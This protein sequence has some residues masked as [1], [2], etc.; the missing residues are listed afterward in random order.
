MRLAFIVNLY[1]PYIVGGNEMLCDD[2]VKALRARGHTVCVLCGRGRELPGPP[3]VTG[4]LEIDLDRRQDTFLGGRLP[5]PWEAFKLHVFSPA[6]YRSTRRW[7]VE[8]QPEL[9]VV[10]NLHM[11]SLAPLLAVKHHGRPF[12]VHLFDKWLYYSLVDL[13]T[14]LR[15]Q[16]PWKRWLIRLSRATLQPLLRRLVGRLDLVS[17]SRFLKDFYLRA[18]FAEGTIEVEHLGVPTSDFARAS[19]PVAPGGRP[20][21]LLFVG[22]LWEGKGPQTAVRALGLLLR[23]GV[24][25]SLDIYGEGVP[26]FVAALEALIEQEGVG[27]QV[28]LHGRVPKSAVPAL[29]RSHDVLVFPSEWDEPFAAVPLEAMSCGMVVVATT[30]GGTPEAV[31]DDESGLLVPPRD[32]QAMADAVRRLAQ[33]PGL[34]QRLGQTA[35]EVVRARFEFA[36]YVD[37]LEVRYARL[38]ARDRG[39]AVPAGTVRARQP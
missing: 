39:K 2:V 11:A 13:E 20:L 19:D 34:R 36:G 38:I 32:P 28:R 5:T 7:L 14:L 25:A 22:A 30:A 15:P 23:S 37:R 9:V 21:R 16:V 8:V 24:R 17:V 27:P 4:A 12:V 35:A 29:C 3:E 33:D 1:P 26:H 10:W 31:V 6:S 18:G